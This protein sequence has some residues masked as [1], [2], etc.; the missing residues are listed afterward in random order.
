MCRASPFDAL[1]SRRGGFHGVA[2]VGT[3]GKPSIWFC[4]RLRHQ[5]MIAP[6]A[7]TS[8]LVSKRKGN[9]RLGQ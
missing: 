6:M 3:C 8:C 2:L 4:V 9:C 7:L 5:G 1:P